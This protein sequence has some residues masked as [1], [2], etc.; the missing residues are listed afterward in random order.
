M[1]KRKKELSRSEK[2]IVA[3]QGTMF[4]FLAPFFVCFGAN[5]TFSLF[6]AALTLGSGLGSGICL[7]VGIL[8]FLTLVVAPIQI[9]MWAVK[10]ICSF[11]K[12]SKKGNNEKVTEKNNEKL[13]DKKVTIGKDNNK[14]KKTEF[15]LGD[16]KKNNHTSYYDDYFYDAKAK[17][18]Q[19]VKK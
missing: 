16:N 18:K 11:L 1:K 14:V 15:I 12:E 4:C 9:S 17:G 19:K 8:S 3:A 10:N 6:S 13:H 2:M 5:A 7:G